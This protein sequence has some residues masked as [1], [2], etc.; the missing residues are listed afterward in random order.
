M[1]VRMVLT[2]VAALSIPSAVASYLPGEI[3]RV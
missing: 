1:L 2:L 3:A